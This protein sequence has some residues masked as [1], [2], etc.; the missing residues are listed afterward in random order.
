MANRILAGFLNDPDEEVRLQAV[1]ALDP[2]QG[3]ARVRQILHEASGRDFRAKSF[4]EREALLAFLGRTRSPEALE[5]LRI[6]LLRAPLFASKGLLELRLAAVAG[7]E[8]MATDEAVGVLQKGALGRTKKV[9]EACTAALVRLPP[10]G[11]EKG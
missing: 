7:L 9:R 5:F 3:G 6:T 2:A 11:A 8:N 1:M 4:K 10:I